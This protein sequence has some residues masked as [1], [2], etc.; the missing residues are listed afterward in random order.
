MTLADQRFPKDPKP[1]PPP[2]KIF[3]HFF[4]VNFSQ[5]SLFAAFGGK[6]DFF[7]ATGTLDVNRAKGRKYT[8]PMGGIPWRANKLYFLAGDQPKAVQMGC[9]ELS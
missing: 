3:G 9:V 7:R 1:A 2:E 4:L 6:S 8:A 5:K